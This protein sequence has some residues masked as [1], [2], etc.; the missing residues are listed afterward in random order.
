[1]KIPIS[2]DNILENIY[3]YHSIFKYDL[4][5][6][7]K[8]L[9]SIKKTEEKNKKIFNYQNNNSKNTVKISNISKLDYY[10]KIKRE[11][12]DG[13]NIVYE[14]NIFNLSSIE[15]SSEEINKLVSLFENKLENS[16]LNLE[17]NFNLYISRHENIKNHHQDLNLQNELKIKE[18][19]EIKTFENMINAF[20]SIGEVE[21]SLNPILKSLE[22][23][24]LNLQIQKSINDIDKI[25]S[26]GIENSMNLL[27][28][29][30]L[31]NPDIYNK[32]YLNNLDYSILNNSKI[33][34]KNL[35]LNI[36]ITDS[37]RRLINLEKAKIILLNKNCN[38]SKNPR[39]KN[40]D[41]AEIKFEIFSNKNKLENK[42]KK[43]I[44]KKDNLINSVAISKKIEFQ[45]LS[46][47]Q[48]KIEDLDQSSSDNTINE[49]LI[50]KYNISNITHIKDKNL[51]DIKKNNI[52]SSNQ[53][54]IQINHSTLNNLVEIN[55]KSIMNLDFFKKLTNSKKV[56]NNNKVY[57]EDFDKILDPNISNSYGTFG[58]L[59]KKHFKSIAK[60]NSIIKPNQ[61]QNLINRLASMLS[62]T[63]YVVKH[64]QELKKHLEINIFREG[65]IGR[66]TIYRTPI[67]ESIA[68]YADDTASGP[69]HRII[70]DYILSILPLYANTH[71]DNSFFAVTFNAL[72]HQAQKFILKIFKAPEGRYTVIQ[73]GN[74]VSGA[75]WRWQEILYSNFPEIISNNVLE[76]KK[77][78]ELITQGNSNDLPIVIMTE[79]EHHSNIL[80]WQKWGFECVPIIQSQNGN[81][82]DA[83]KD[84]QLKIETFC[85]Q[86][87]LVIV[88]TSAASN[89]TSQISP[90]DKI[91]DLINKIKEESPDCKEKIIWSIDCA[92]YAS[93]KL[94]DISKINPDA[95]FLSPHKLTGG[96]ATCGLLIFKNEIYPN[97]EDPTQPGGG[98]V[99]G[100]YGYTRK[101]TIYSKDIAAR[102]TPGTPGII[103]FIR[104]A[105]TFQLLDRVGFDIIESREHY[106]SK[107]VFN[108]ITELNFNWKVLGLKYQ[109][110]I[111]GVKD[112]DKRLSVFACILL[113]E[114][115]NKIPY[116]FAHRLMSD[117]FGIQLR[118]GCNCAGPLGV[119]LLKMDE[120]EINFIATKIREGDPTV[121]PGWIRF[122]VHF[123]FTEEDI[124]YLI[125]CLKFVTEQGTT[126]MNKLYD[127]NAD[128]SYSM[129]YEFILE[130]LIKSKNRTFNLNEEQ[131]NKNENNIGFENKTNNVEN[132]IKNEL[133][134]SVDRQ[135]SLHYIYDNLVLDVFNPF[136]SKEVHESERSAYL[137]KRIELG[138]SIIEFIRN[139]KL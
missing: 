55:N 88:S 90:L 118:S 5:S 39:I 89:I 21:N 81:W 134:N 3:Y 19:F 102:E 99:D 66:N 93:H 26:E 105:A 61:N 101:E 43:K 30:K 104:A 108:R 117:L 121:K 103:Q 15:S 94:V 109:I 10:E 34:D 83:I 71:S 14:K 137:K 97:N 79:Y 129:R 73:A 128:G 114:N 85:T 62:M 50:N 75:I 98:T 13:F 92:A 111:L 29:I 76:Y 56:S 100:V 16:R 52:K 48:N 64:G 45:N 132:N 22:M 82:E 8:Y 136:Q 11:L 110:D 9:K 46:N 58:N 41:D 12:I 20:K 72:Y 95:I 65:I 91:G 53:N 31:E 113:N 130:N 112:M 35:N 23:I 6:N 80:S 115:G 131:K 106:L 69:P 84:L 133:F 63:S 7:I 138:D 44:S 51:R 135:A 40:C 78:Q 107:M 27:N 70:E 67:G 125:Y 87:P 96:P 37:N 57:G 18:P 24:K 119:S 77:R 2:Y 123:S 49:A 127:R 4:S 38:P 25:I 32:S 74:G 33:I 122:N 59:I 86:R 36:Q 126:I 28:K 120:E 42:S 116:Q 60:E 124:E 54:Q 139:S 68:F 47:N 1:L 17:K